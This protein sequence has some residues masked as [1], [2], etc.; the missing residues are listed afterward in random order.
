MAKRRCL[1]DGRAEVPS[2]VDNSMQEKAHDA[3]YTYHYSVR[4][5]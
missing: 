2:Y 5:V 1:V 3:L 4:L